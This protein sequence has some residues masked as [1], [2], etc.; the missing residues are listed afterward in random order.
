MQ[1]A[2]NNPKNKH[3]KPCVTKAKNFLSNGVHIDYHLPKQAKSSY[4]DNKIYYK[5]LFI[6][7]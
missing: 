5:H 3:E 1:A 2:N 4:Y 7:R 6:K